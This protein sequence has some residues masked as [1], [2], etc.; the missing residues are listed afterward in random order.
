MKK[1][2]STR[3][4]LA[5][6]ALTAGIAVPIAALAAELHAPHVGTIGNGLCTWHFVNNQTQGTGDISSLLDAFFS[7]GDVLDQ[8]P[9]KVLPNGNLQ[10]S[11]QT[12]GT[13]TLE[14]ASTGAVLGNLL[15]SDLTC[16]P[17]T[18]TT[19]QSTPTTTVP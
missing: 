17:T 7:C 8:S 5:S 9:S 2:L 1:Q 13:C 15:L 12:N 6:L 11:F 18:T 19:T 4:V 3:N 10:Y 14:G 16:P